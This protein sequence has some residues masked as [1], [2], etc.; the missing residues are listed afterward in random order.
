[1]SLA[2]GV[3][4]PASLPNIINDLFQNEKYR[5][6]GFKYNLFFSRANLTKQQQQQL[7]YS[8]EFSPMNFN[9]IFQTDKYNELGLVSSKLELLSFV[10]K[11]SH[12]IHGVYFD[13]INQP[14]LDSDILVNSK[15]PIKL[16]ST[17][18]FVTSNY[19]ELYNNVLGTTV[20][21]GLSTSIGEDKPYAS[22]QYSHQCRYFYETLS[23]NGLVDADIPTTILTGLS[24]NL[25]TC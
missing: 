2:K 24:E 5:D 17:A 23:V 15:N 21:L 16:S 22:L 25:Q 20:I 4:P 11:D 9:I 10:R 19:V 7:I 18:R 6:G 13:I 12:Y 8:P 14:R 1:M 3:P